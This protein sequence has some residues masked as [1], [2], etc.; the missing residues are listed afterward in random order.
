MSQLVLHEPS[1]ADVAAAIEAAADLPVRI[2]SSWLSALR[3]IAKAMDKPWETIPARWTAARFSIGR[4]HHALVGANPKT[5]ANH[6]SN[7]RAALM[8]F[9]KEKGVPSRGMPFTADWDVIRKKLTDTRSRSVLSSLMRYC[10]AQGTG[11]G[12]VDEVVLD[13]YMR[14]RAETTA[15]A[16]DK[17][18]R[19]TIARVWNRCVDVVE[20]W[21]AQRLIEPAVEATTGPTWE[22]FPQGLRSDL[23]N[24]FQ[25][26]RRIRR[27]GKGKRVRPCKESTIRMRRASI[28]AAIRTAV[29]EGVPITRLTSLKSLLHPE[30][31]GTVVDAYWKAGGEDP[32]TYTIDLASRFLSMAR[33]LSCFE[34][35]V[36]DQLV[37]IRDSVEIYRRGGMT[38]KNQAVIRQVLSGDVW[39]RV[40]NLPDVLMKQARLL[41]HEA[42]IKAA[43]A[44]QLAVA[45]GIETVAPVRLGN[46]SRITLGQNLIKPGGLDTPYRLVFPHYDVKNRIDLDHPLDSELT[47]LIDEYVHEFRPWLLRGSNE[48]WLFPGE[49]GGSKD[50]K[51]LSDQIAERIENA[52]GLVMTV[53]QFRHAAAALWLAHNPGDYET[54]RR[55]LGHRNIQ[56]TIRFYC[57][58]ETTQAN[59][60]FGAVVRKLRNKDLEVRTDNCRALENA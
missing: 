57:G 2:R 7:A 12:S 60:M 55:V 28:V 22:E 51:T 16:T 53:H 6:K 50:P 1:F 24:H 46:L 41:R 9:G 48:L 31:V 3:Q 47:A 23:E 32:S 5:L 26:L 21:P 18:A 11:P 56:T 39:F 25:R 37:E 54:V 15:L 20:G 42:P 8:W 17:A 52:T 30:V 19:R 36:L 10:S 34:E 27:T 13:H 38:P 35:D 40:V 33:E 29:G 43:V 45:I 49:A 44:A 14:Y 59:I 4:L 58:L